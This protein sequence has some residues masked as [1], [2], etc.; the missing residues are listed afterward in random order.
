[1]KIP[2]SLLNPTPYPEDE[3]FSNLGI[4]DMSKITALNEDTNVESSDTQRTYNT[5]VI[6]VKN[7]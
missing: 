7:H 6:T 3:E 5:A 2:D 1:M 4:M